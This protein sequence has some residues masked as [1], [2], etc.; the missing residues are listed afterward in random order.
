MQVKIE[1]ISKW[2]ESMETDLHILANP[3]HI[4]FPHHVFSV[5]VRVP[6]RTSGPKTTWR[7]KDLLQLTTFRLH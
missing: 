4:I 7:G 2:R 5:L 3:F 6:I 1:V